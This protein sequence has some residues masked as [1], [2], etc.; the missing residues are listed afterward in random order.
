MAQ[1]IPV[2]RLHRFNVDQCRIFLPQTLIEL[3]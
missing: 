1:L 3:Q 2:S